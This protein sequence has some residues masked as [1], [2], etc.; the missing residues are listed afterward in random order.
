MFKY[1]KIDKIAN[2]GMTNSLHN[3]RSQRKKQSLRSGVRF[4]RN[5]VAGNLSYNNLTIKV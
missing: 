3:S 4:Q 1:Q 5:F 2:K